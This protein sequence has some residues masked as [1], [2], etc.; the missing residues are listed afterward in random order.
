MG[1][2]KIEFCVGSFILQI[3]R[4]F[5][6]RKR[7]KFQKETGGNQSPKVNTFYSFQL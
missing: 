2:K 7:R 3:M 4:T 1:V 6:P 5:I